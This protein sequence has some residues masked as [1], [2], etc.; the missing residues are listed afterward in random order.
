MTA[1]SLE[2]PR[3]NSE[4]FGHTFCIGMMSWG[5]RVRFGQLTAVMIE[6]QGNYAL[7]KGRLLRTVICCQ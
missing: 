1:R 2:T 5:V 3:A 4:L 7:L 6:N